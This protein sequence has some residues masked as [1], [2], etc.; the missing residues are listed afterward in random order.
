[1]RQFNR[2]LKIIIS[3]VTMLL[4]VKFYI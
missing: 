1:M 4:A 3:G 2:P